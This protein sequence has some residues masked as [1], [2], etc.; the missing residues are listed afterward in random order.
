[1][2]FLA[3]I[4]YILSFQVQQFFWEIQIK[5]LDPSL[6]LGSLIF[7]PHGIRVMSLIFFKLDILL[8]LYFAHVVTGL[9]YLQDL[10]RPID[11]IFK[12]FLSIT[13]MALAYIFIIQLQQKREFNI[14]ISSIFIFTLLSSLFNSIL[15]GLY[16]Y[17]V[18]GGF[19]HQF[20]SFLIGDILGAFT[21]YILF[22]SIKYFYS[23]I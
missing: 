8:G 19:Q 12:S 7:L 5:I 16:G 15:N 17:L 9:L 22:Y 13:A 6:Y 1:M 14:T 23:R 20:F 3:F 4:F 18:Y 11:I 10:L 21:I 2:N